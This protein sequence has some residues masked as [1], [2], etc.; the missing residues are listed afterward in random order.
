MLV[1]VEVEVDIEVKIEV[2]IY[3][4]PISWYHILWLARLLLPLLSELGV[5]DA[6]EALVEERGEDLYLQ[7]Y[8]Y[9]YIS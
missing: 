8:I 4:L 2:D 1:V 5:G 9:I 7:L 6:A 3:S